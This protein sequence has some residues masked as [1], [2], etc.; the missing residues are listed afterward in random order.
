MNK[1]QITKFLEL[2]ISMAQKYVQM[3]REERAW[4]IIRIK[5]IN[6]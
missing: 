2:S 3:R 6:D 5:Q 1:S 4:V